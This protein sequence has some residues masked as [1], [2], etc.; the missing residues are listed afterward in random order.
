MIKNYKK[1]FTLIELLVVI[2]IIGI[3]AS[4]VLI[5]TSKTRA[6]GADASI[7][8]NLATIKLQ[9]EMLNNSKGCFSDDCSTPVN[10]PCDDT[11]DPLAAKAYA[12]ALKSSG[13]SANAACTISSDASSFAVSV[14]LKSDNTQSWCVDSEGWSDVGTAAAGVCS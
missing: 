11:V 3:L 8:S 7:K 14:P 10:T 2:A 4:V 6:Q 13:N 9:A 1:G 5:S 12:S